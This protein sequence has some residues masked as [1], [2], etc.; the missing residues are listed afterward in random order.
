M[1]TMSTQLAVLAVGTLLALGGCR[2]HEEAPHPA[3]LPEAGQSPA[4][5]ASTPAPADDGSDVLQSWLG[6]W[7]GP[8]GTYLV[9][10][11][12][13]PGYRLTIRDLDGETHYDGRR[14]GGHI[15]FERQGTTESIRATDGQATGMKWLLDKK[16]CLTIK[17][18][19]GYCRD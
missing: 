14:V 5:P 19:E 11:R 8:E 6:R 10:D 15:E 12:G 13:E 3:P 7:E 1:K 2:Q 4:P 16:S 9:I 17:P 18:G